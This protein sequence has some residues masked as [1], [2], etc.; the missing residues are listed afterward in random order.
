MMCKKALLAL[1]GA[2]AVCRCTSL[3]PRAEHGTQQIWRNY[4]DAKAAIDAIVPMKSTRTDLHGAGIDPRANAAVSIL[5][6][7]GVRAARQPQCDIRTG[8]VMA[9]SRLRVAPPSTSSRRR[10]WP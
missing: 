1:P 3:L 5:S 2:A 6:F 4:D 10:E 8:T 9:S 7:G